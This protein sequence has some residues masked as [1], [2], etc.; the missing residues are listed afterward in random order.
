LPEYDRETPTDEEQD[1]YLTE[2]LLTEKRV[3]RWALSGTPFAKATFHRQS[4]LRRVL[5]AISNR[6]LDTVREEQRSKKTP[7]DKRRNTEVEEGKKQSKRSGT[8]VLIELGVKTGLSLL[9]SLLK[10]AWTAKESG[11]IEI[12]NNVLKTACAVLV[13]LP[14]GSLVG[15]MKIGPLGWQSLEEVTEF[16]VHVAMPESPA[17]TSGRQLA[18]ELLLLLAL[19]RA[20]LVHLLG[21]IDVAM[22][23]N[24][25]VKQ[26]VDGDDCGAVK[27][28]TVVLQQVVTEVNKAVAPDDKV[29]NVSRLFSENGCDQEMIAADK[30]AVVLLSE[31]ICQWLL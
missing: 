8:E 11:S 19:Q 29:V 20:S 14:P 2:L 3:C 5:T 25:G 17:D 12:C 1:H 22:K 6:Y 28:P 16:L 31:V 13:G 4:V 27:V 7:E 21:W 30:G 24:S 10:Q 18:L 26:P 23:A 9:F 15:K